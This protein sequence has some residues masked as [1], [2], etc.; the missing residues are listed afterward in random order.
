MSSYCAALVAATVPV[1]VLAAGSYQPSFHCTIL[2]LKTR[3]LWLPSMQRNVEELTGSC[4]RLD[5]QGLWEEEH[6]KIFFCTPQTFR[7]DVDRGQGSSWESKQA[8]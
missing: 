2:H 5:R 7:N 8:F 4:K 3:L 6:K 1:P